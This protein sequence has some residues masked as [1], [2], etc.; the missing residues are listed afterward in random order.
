ML[1][2]FISPFVVCGIIMRFIQLQLLVHGFTLDNFPVKNSRKSHW[3]PRSRATTMTGQT[4]IRPRRERADF[5]EDRLT[6]TGLVDRIC[7]DSRLPGSFSIGEQR[8]SWCIGKNCSSSSPDVDSRWREEES[9]TLREHF[10]IHRHIHS[11]LVNAWQVAEAASR[12]PA[13]CCLRVWIGMPGFLSRRPACQ[14]RLY[15]LFWL[16]L[17]LTFHTCRCLSSLH[18]A[19]PQRKR[20]HSGEQVRETGNKRVTMDTCAGPYDSCIGPVFIPYW[21][22][23]VNSKSL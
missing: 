21:R 5:H 11:S 23:Y 2:V 16:S 10:L 12:L 6:E 14:S 13:K 1:F 20:L 3:P 17:P 18:F 19:V 22:E 4:S 15:C 9:R 7:S 8:E